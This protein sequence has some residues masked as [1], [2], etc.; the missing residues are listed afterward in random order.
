MASQRR[1]LVRMWAVAVTLCV[2][3]TMSVAEMLST[4]QPRNYFGTNSMLV[5]CSKPCGKQSDS[6][7]AYELYSYERLEID[8]CEEVLCI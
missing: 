4:L 6:L 1:P 2:L 5:C 3:P 8:R 7:E